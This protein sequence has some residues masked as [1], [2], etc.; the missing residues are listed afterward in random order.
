MVMML[1]G[2]RLQVILRSWHLELA[3]LCQ[4]Q[5]VKRLL[6]TTIHHSPSSTR[7]QILV[8]I[9]Q[10]WPRSF[11]LRWYSLWLTLV[12]V[13]HIFNPSSNMLLHSL[14]RAA[15]ASSS[16]SKVCSLATSSTIRSFQSSAR[17]LAPTFTA[18]HQAPVTSQS[19]SRSAHAISNPTLAGIE[20]RWESMPPQ[21]QADLWMA[22]RDRMKVDWHEMTL[23]EKKAGTKCSYAKRASVGLK[24][25]KKL[26]SSNVDGS[27]GT[28]LKRNLSN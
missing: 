5:V 9:L 7:A 25:L 10:Y 16:T 22:L 15:R 13:E 27:N 3:L 23:Q 4:V 21:E 28:I 26:G 12:C 11:R 1:G 18:V 20:K 17:S 19:Q 24:L 8:N 6:L 2:V 14:P